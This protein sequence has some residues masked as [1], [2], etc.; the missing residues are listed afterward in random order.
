MTNNLVKGE[1]RLGAPSIYVSEYD[2]QDEDIQLIIETIG[3]EETLYNLGFDKD[4]WY[5]STDSF[6]EVME[7][8]HRTLSGKIVEGKRYSSHE[9]MDDEWI[10]N[11]NPSDE[12]KMMA[13]K[14]KSY[15]DEIRNLSKT[16]R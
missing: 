14:D 2:L 7:C 10:K 9:R 4:R 8:K 13:R 3:F 5:N 16:A 6:Y 12:C 11:G 1:D 15:L